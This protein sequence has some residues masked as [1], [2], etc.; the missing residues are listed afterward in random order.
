M[1]EGLDL[2]SIITYISLVVAIICAYFAYRSTNASERSAEAAEKSAQ[3]AKESAESSKETALTSRNQY[4][5]DIEKQ[6]YQICKAGG[7]D[8]VDKYLKTFPHLKD[9]EKRIIRENSMKRRVQ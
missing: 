6:A 8:K 5:L 3:S 9:D 1:D 2:M 4:I 7:V